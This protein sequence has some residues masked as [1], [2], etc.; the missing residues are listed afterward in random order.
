MRLPPT[1][2]RRGQAEGS[3]PLS[4]TPPADGAR[5]VSGMDFSELGSNRGSGHTPVDVGGGAGP[6][7]QLV[8]TGDPLDLTGSKVGA[9][10]K[11]ETHRVS[12][13]NE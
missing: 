10:S 7:L 5:T 8:S 1:N 13:A 9:G 2:D 6:V 3:P 4:A 11:G 12:V